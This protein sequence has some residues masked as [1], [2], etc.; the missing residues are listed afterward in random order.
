[1]ATGCR[2]RCP[3]RKSCSR[4]VSPKKDIAPTP[5]QIEQHWRPRGM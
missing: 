2:R 4:A 5:A 3:R 1:V